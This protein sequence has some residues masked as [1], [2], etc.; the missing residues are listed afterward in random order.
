MTEIRQ[1]CA[2]NFTTT[3]TKF[4]K[5]KGSR[6][7]SL[8][9]SFAK[10]QILSFK[11]SF[12]FILLVWSE[13]SSLV[14]VIPFFLDSG[15]FYNG[16]LIARHLKWR[17]YVAGQTM[18]AS[19]TLSNTLTIPNGWHMNEQIMQFYQKTMCCRTNNARFKYPALALHQE[20]IT[21][22]NT[23]ATDT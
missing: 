12:V 6:T 2:W 8:S 10:H 23:L 13:R 21:L 11:P 19:K 22:S 9:R 15:S 4:R 14:I 17:Q 1:L 7:F 20:Q 3:K 18:R 5:I 16:D